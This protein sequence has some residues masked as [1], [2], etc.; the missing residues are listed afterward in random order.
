MVAFLVGNVMRTSASIFGLSGRIPAAGPN[1]YE[2]FQM[3]VGLV[4]FAIRFLMVEGYR[5]TGAWARS[6]SPHAF[7]TLWTGAS[8]QNVRQDLGS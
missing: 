5:R 3:L 6:N 1:C 2:L 7:G 4:Q 8:I